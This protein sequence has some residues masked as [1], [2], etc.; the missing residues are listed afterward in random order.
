MTIKWYYAS[1]SIRI[2]PDIKAAAYKGLVRLVI[3]IFTDFETTLCLYWN[4]NESIQL[5]N[6][7]ILVQD[8]LPSDLLHV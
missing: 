8:S 2:H 5:S 7:I 1:A 3:D 4:K 6:Q